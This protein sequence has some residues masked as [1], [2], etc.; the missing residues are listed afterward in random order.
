MQNRRI[1]LI[2]SAP[3]PT[4]RRRAPEPSRRRAPMLKRHLPRAD[5]NSP[6]AL[7]P[8]VSPFLPRMS[9]AGLTPAGEVGSR[10]RLPRFCSAPLARALC[11]GAGAPPRA[12]R[13]QRH[14]KK[15]AGAALPRSPRARLA[16]AALP[17]PPA[18]QPSRA[19]RSPA[20]SPLPRLPLPSAARRGEGGVDGSMWGELNE[21][22]RGGA[23][24]RSS[25]LAI[26]RAAE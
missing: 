25:G 5:A 2:L 3:A 6:A 15:P 1:R 10:K 17:P 4:K 9:S 24:G 20:A 7:R 14:C 19:A 23:E 11:F 26:G 21:G 8:R 16:P 12:G 22:E 18:C 13:G